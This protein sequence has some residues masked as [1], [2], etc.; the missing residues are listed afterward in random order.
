M[1]V[2]NIDELCVPCTCTCIYEKCMFNVT[3]KQ[4]I[5]NCFVFDVPLNAQLFELNRGINVILLSCNSI[6]IAAPPDR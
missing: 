5:S 2:Y 4:L 3:A 6:V 1:T